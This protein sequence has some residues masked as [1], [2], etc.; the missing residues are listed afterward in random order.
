MIGSTVFRKGFCTHALHLRGKTLRELAELLGY[1][2]SRLAAGASV[3][4]LQSVPGPHD[5]QLSGYTHFSDG[6]V[7]G[8][9]LKPAERAPF[10]MEA[11]LKTEQGW[12]DADLLKHKQK[13]IGGKITISGPERLAKLE[14]FTGYSPGELFPPGKG[15]FQV[16]LIREMRFI[17]KAQILPGQKWEGDY[18]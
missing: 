4:F 15:V 5:F 13:M 6:A 3:L 7:Q 9:L 10:Q 11:L 17:V 2:Q 18:K 12:S 14:P 1:E 8:H 16:R